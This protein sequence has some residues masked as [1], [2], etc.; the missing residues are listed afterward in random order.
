MVKISLRFCEPIDARASDRWM[1]TRMKDVDIDIA[2]G[3]A[4][5]MDPA[6]FLVQGQ[7][8][9]REGAEKFIR[10][11]PPAYSRALLSSSVRLYIHYIMMFIPSYRR[12]QSSR[13]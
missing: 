13:K 10:R 5:W 11:L 12:E 2:N 8:F 1:G 3:Q 7:F 6:G 9:A 4:R